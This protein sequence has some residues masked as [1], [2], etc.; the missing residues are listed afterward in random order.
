MAML[1]SPSEA[2][3]FS[4]YGHFISTI[5]NLLLLISTWELSVR[6]RVIF[7]VK[8]SLSGEVMSTANETELLWSRQSYRT[9]M[10][11]VQIVVLS[12]TGSEN[13]KT[14][15]ESQFGSKWIYL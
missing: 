9:A 4:R 14:G 1:H 8:T 5:P 2:F 6:G 7:S 13:V 11:V 15:M 12:I 10:K 3:I